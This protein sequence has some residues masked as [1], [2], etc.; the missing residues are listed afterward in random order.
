M[1]IPRNIC[2]NDRFIIR[3]NFIEISSVLSSEIC[4][5][6]AFKSRFKQFRIRLSKV[7][8]MKNDSQIKRREKKLNR[9]K[10]RTKYLQIS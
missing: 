10:S 5:A 2:K 6:T 3:R 9:P 4:Q 8:G 7:W 1:Q